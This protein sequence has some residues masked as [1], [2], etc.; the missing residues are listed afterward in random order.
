[1]K[2]KIQIKQGI[3]FLN[4]YCQGNYSEAML[5]FE[6]V[7]KYD[8]DGHKA[9]EAIL[10]MAK[11]KVKEKDFYGTYYTLQRAT[12]LNLPFSKTKLEDYWNLT[13]GVLSLIK[14]KTKS[15]IKLLVSMLEKENINK[16]VRGL[17]H[18]YRAYGHMIQGEFEVITLC[19]S[20]RLL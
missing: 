1:M 17:G 4:N 14:R 20:N 7:I 8:K 3:Y 12:K 6:Q 2:G 16:T 15:G 19:Y 5:N 9:M 13:E 18:I 11:I 10:Q